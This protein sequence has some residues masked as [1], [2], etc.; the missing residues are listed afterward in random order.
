V[1]DYILYFLMAALLALIPFLFVLLGWISQPIPS[2]VS[3]SLSIIM[4]VAIPIF[5]G[6]LIITELQ[7]RM[8]I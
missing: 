1:E 2:F 7:K 3:V 4:L 8:H 5:R 6:R